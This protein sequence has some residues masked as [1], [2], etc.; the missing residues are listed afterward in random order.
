MSLQVDNKLGVHLQA[1]LSQSTCCA[2]QLIEKYHLC[3]LPLRQVM[4]ATDRK[5]VLGT[6][7]SHCLLYRP[8]QAEI[9]GLC[10]E[11]LD[12]DH[13]QGNEDA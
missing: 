5:N 11:R 7:H 2:K 1:Q 4:E 10:F 13:N 6:I 9:V 12:Y 8:L 3:V